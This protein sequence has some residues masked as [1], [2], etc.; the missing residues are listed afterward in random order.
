MSIREERSLAVSRLVLA[1]LFI[2]IAYTSVLFIEIPLLPSVPFLKY[3]IKDVFF[4]LAAGILNPVYSL[5]M[6]FAVPFL[7]MLTTSK[8]GI[9]GFIMNFLAC[10]S[11]VL[12]VA[13]TINRK[14]NLKRLICGLL[15]GIVTLNITMILWNYIFTPIFIPTMS[16][17]TL[18]P[19]LLNAILPF[20]LLKSSFNFILSLALYLSLWP[21][22]QK[23][24]Q[25][26][27][28][29]CVDSN[30][31]SRR[32]GIIVLLVFAVLTGILY[33][34]LILGII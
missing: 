26:H 17:S 19:F 15:L 33:S 29:N 23:V 11:F 31:S 28:F 22:L 14:R 9:I 16:R 8:S 6:C 27:H 5:A 30:K 2:A 34:L 4:V 1:A 18:L 20:N 3:D 7:Q 12:P 10:I 21:V 25:A 13:Y 24:S 32:V